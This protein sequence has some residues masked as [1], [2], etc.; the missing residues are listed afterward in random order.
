M[1]A[2]ATDQA[3]QHLCVDMQRIFAEATPWRVDW[4]KRIAPI[5]AE[6]AG[7]RPEQT[8]FT[9]FIPPAT[10]DDAHGAWRDYYRKWDNITR[11]KMPAEMLD[12]MPP[13]RR[14][15]P[16]AKVLD[17]PVYSPWFDGRLHH[18]LQSQSVRR[19]VISGGET[20]VCVLAAVLGAIDH[21][22]FVTLVSDAVCSGAD[23]T[24]D[25]SLTVL[26]SRFSLQVELATAEEILRDVG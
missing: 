3:W 2:L 12:L 16:P 10:P 8:I 1:T 15:V 21:G 6:L 11:V 13:L 17:K 9:R 25:A 23:Q 18:Y 7:R 5:V 14:L 19:V 20:D 26:A 22:Y 24:H 4:M